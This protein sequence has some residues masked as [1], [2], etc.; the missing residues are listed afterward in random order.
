MTTDPLP[1][2]PIMDRMVDVVANAHM[3]RAA[4]DDP[5][6]TP[7]QRGIATT[8]IWNNLGPALDAVSAD[9]VRFAQALCEAT[10]LTGVL[11]ELLEDP[12]VVEAGVDDPDPDVVIAHLGHVLDELD[13]LEPGAH[14]DHATRTAAFLELIRAEHPG[15]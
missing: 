12:P 15:P 6:L 8:A 2:R 5:E 9:Q 14:L 11:R 3:L 13:V 4:A 1:P 10:T 7:L